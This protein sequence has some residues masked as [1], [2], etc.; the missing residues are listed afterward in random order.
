[1]NDEVKTTKFHVVALGAS[2]GGLYALEQFFDNMPADSGMAF[3]VIQHLSPDF[4]SLMDDILGRR[5]T[6][7]IK[8]V[9]NGMGI[10]PNNVYLIPPKSQMTIS[11][12]RLYLRDKLPQPYFELPID[13]FLQSMAEDIGELA[14][15]IVLSGTGSDGS[16]GIQEIK[17]KCGLVIVQSPDTAQFDGMPR[18]ALATGQV[19]YE[20]P[21][22]KIPL[23]LTEYIADPA[24]IRLNSAKSITDEIDEDSDR[25][26]NEIF[27][28]LRRSFGLDFAKYKAAT[29][30]R[31]IRRRMELTQFSSVADYT[32]MLSGD[33]NEQNL[34]Y[35]DLLIGVTEFFRDPDVYQVLENEVIPE[36]FQRCLPGEDI[37]VW[38]AGCATGEEPYSLAILLF[39]KAEEFGFTNKITIFA[40]DVHRASLDFASSGLYDLQRLG[41]MTQERID[42]HFK[43]EANGLYRVSPALRK[44]VVFAPHNLTTDP[45]FTKIDLISCRNLLIYFLPEVQERAISLFHYA[46]RVDG[47][48]L[49]GSS[50]GLGIYTAEFETIYSHCK[51]F[52]KQRDLRLALDLGST[53]HLRAGLS[54]VPVMQ[55]S[56]AKTVPINRQILH[57]YDYMLSRFMPPGLLIDEERHVLHYFG[58]VDPFLKPKAGRVEHDALEML[59]DSLH[60]AVSTAL[61]RAAKNHEKVLT[62]NVRV[63]NAESEF[64]LDL[65]IE[66]ILDE[67][68]RSYHFLISFEQIHN[69]EPP[70]RSIAE[71]STE[72]DAERQYRQYIQ[73]LEFELQSTRETLQAT[74][75]EL[76]TSNEELQATNE[77][78]L[79]ANEELQSTNEELH[80][81]NE[82]L[83]TVNAEFERKNTELRQLNLDHDSLLSSIQIGIIFLDRTLRIRKY[84]DAVQGIFRLI[85]QDLGRPID[86]ISYSLTDQKELMEDLRSI[87][88]G[89]EAIGR[90]KQFP[91]GRWLLYR[92]LPFRSEARNIDGVV[93]TFTEI[94]GVKEA[95]QRLAQLN[96]ELERKVDE[97]TAALKEE[98]SQRTWAMEEMKKAKE[99]AELA[100]R[101][102]SQFLA[103]MSHEIRTPMNG[104]IGFL[105]LLETTPLTDEQKSFTG[106]MRFSAENLLNIIG[107]I[108]DIS[109]IEAGAMQVE[110]C[111]FRLDELLDMVVR[112]SRP[113]AEE[114]GLAF[115]ANISSDISHTV[116]G[117]PI[118]IKQVLLNLLNNA[119]KFT[120]SGNVTMN[121]SHLNRNDNEHCV[122]FAVTDTGCGITREKQQEIFEPFVQADG[123]MT[124]NYGG[125]G[126]GL[127]ICKK[128]AALMGG[129]ITLSSIPGKGSSFY[130]DL[131]LQ[132]CAHVLLKSEPQAELPAIWNDRHLKI[133]VVDD[134]DLNR[135]LTCKL[136]EVSGHTTIGAGSGREALELWNKGGIDLILMD[137]EM[138]DMDGVKTSEAIRCLE[139]EQGK[140]A[141]IPIIALTAH[142][143]QGERDK[144]V[145]A[146]MDGYVTKPVLLGELLL[147]MNRVVENIE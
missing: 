116:E 22:Q 21:P 132:L 38:S 66:P 53:R 124:R 101:T 50:E 42:R 44:L 125:T 109:K 108:L 93:L 136:A 19:D 145:A 126:L 64:L 16:R 7:S 119:V 131:P 113:Q 85:P 141:H 60:I 98:I 68:S 92:A 6:M 88:E 35:H 52:R 82:E 65:N 105:Q 5:T 40:T 106:L 89:S 112:I 138:P 78:L 71:D 34:L 110:T 120:A 95:E 84:N 54:N 83:Y 63:P 4:K 46:L 25:E 102:K 79:A 114:K 146:G 122:R 10:E 1:M 20:L 104:V 45:P 57:D 67:K 26:F 117:D 91:D 87:I 135:Q 80:S 130:F 39:E 129:D 49:L 37:R 128:L 31:R 81:I 94:T 118:K 75:E 48:L 139:A 62:R 24:R 73:D 23:L 107:D 143:L 12:G 27:S 123:S 100:N 47:V 36:L 18:S 127:T 3:V 133:M 97:R 72:F 121:V 77:E 30:G 59:E 28:T 134:H 99:T 111:C 15:A 140:G 55:P 147:E 69:V 43:R 13:I 58:N 86:H 8:R 61:Q 14:I 142:A 137:L 11:G 41:N 51:L 2:A 115:I 29:V 144:A 74:I 70:P 17:K 56:S 90:E 103:T 9:E 32:V 96:E 33:Q 76:Q